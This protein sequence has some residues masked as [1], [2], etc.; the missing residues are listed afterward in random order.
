[1]LKHLGDIEL[2]PHAGP[3]GFDHAA[4]HRASGRVYLAHTA[5][6]A[7]DVIDGPAGRLVATVEGLPGVAG[8]LVSD[9]GGLVF[10]SN[11]R[12][13][14]VGIFP[15]DG[16]GAVARVPVGV[17]PNGLAHDAHRQRLLV[18]HVGDPAVPGSFTVA[19]VDPARRQVVAELGLPGRTRWAVHDPVADVFHVN[20]MS[21]AVIAVID[22]ERFTLQRLVEI[23]STGPHGLDL[24][25]EARRLYCACDGGH[26]M[27]I[28]ADDG[29]IVRQATLAGVP[30]VV[31]V[32]PARR[33]LYVAV[34]EPGLL[35]VFDTRT[36]TR[37][38]A[39]PTARDAHTLGLDPERHLVY[40]FLPATPRAAVYEDHS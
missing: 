18:A 12:E 29:T 27:E 35:E 20:V 13:N 24:D 19:L 11:R 9:E 23:P 7:V 30:D 6:D 39:V 36:L 10:T 16:P 32:D 3:G 8:A 1:M 40:A 33:R 15:V 37:R 38:Q 17:R 4:I 14:T 21:P 22:A 26:L 2:P 25:A 34:G 31:F 5:N 28:D